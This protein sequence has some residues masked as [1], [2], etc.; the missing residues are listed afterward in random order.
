MISVWHR[1][2]NDLKDIGGRIRDL[3]WE[4][5]RESHVPRLITLE[6][7][8]KHMNGAL[9]DCSVTIN[10]PVIAPRAAEGARVIAS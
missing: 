9:K 8:H 2:E 5:E 4:V 1:Q 10:V 6:Y 7:M 3:T